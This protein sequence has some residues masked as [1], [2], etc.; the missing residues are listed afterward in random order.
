[1]YVRAVR[2]GEAAAAP[3]CRLAKGAETKGVDVTWPFADVYFLTEKNLTTGGEVV[4]AGPRAGIAD[5]RLHALHRNA[6]AASPKT[7][8][9]NPRP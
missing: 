6:R 5:R 1:M 2:K 3:G 9:S 7:A 8:S 4:G